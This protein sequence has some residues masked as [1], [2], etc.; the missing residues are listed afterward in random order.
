[1]AGNGGRA[2]LGRGGIVGKVGAEGVVACKSWRAARLRWRLGSNNAMIKGI[3]PSLAARHILQTSSPSAPLLPTIPPLPK[4]ALPPLLAIPTVLPKATLP[5]LP[6]APLPTLPTAPTLPKPTLPSLPSTQFPSLPV[7]T[8]PTMPTAPKVTLPP[9]PATSLPTMPTTIPSIPAIPT[10][11]PAIPFLSPPPSATK[12]FLPLEFKSGS[13]IEDAE[14]LLLESFSQSLRKVLARLEMEAIQLKSRGWIIGMVGNAGLVVDGGGEKK[15]FLGRVVGMAG[16]DG[17]V[18]G[19]VGSEVAGKGGSVTFGTAG[20]VG[21]VGFGKDGIWVLGS[22]GNEDF[23]KVVGAVG[24]VGKGV[25]GI[26]GNAAL[27]SVGMAGSGGN[28]AFGKGGIVGSAGAAGG[29][30][31]NS[32]RA[33]RL[34][35][36]LESDNA[37]RRNITRP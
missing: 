32:W 20:I 6:T 22:G 17:I 3:H 31:C 33:A 16:I 7:P 29:E 23:G 15:G 34:T 37:I 19:M 8:L 4:T 1:M 2:D 12:A 9:L 21:K 30:V 35:W 26:G 24:S 18:V 11:I 28:V 10:N 27:G 5:P 13:R 14:Q 25:V 36:M